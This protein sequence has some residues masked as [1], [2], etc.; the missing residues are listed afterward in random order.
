MLTHEIR[1]LDI[2][3]W[4]INDASLDN[5]QDVMRGEK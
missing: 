1:R 4:T 3:R 5:I 2:V